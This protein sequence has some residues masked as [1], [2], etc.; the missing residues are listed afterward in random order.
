MTRPAVIRV[1]STVVMLF[2][3]SA[4]STTKVVQEWHLDTP[5][6][7]PPDKIAVVVMLPEAL[8][9]LSVE[10]VVAEDIQSAGGNAVPV[11]MSPSCAV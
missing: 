2:A 1:I 5:A 8:Q 6:G 7:P 3:L 10:R 4:C 11:L 9:R